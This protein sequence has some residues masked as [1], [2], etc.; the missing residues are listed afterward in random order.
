[1]RTSH[2]PND[3]R[4]YELCDRYGIYVIDEANLET[5]GV[6]GRLT[7]DPQWLSA[8]VERASRMVERDKNHPSVV[9]WS[10]GNESGMGPNHAAMAGW[11]REHDPTRPIHYE[12]AAARPRDPAWVDVVS[13]MYTRIP[14]LVKMAEDPAED[15]PVVLCEYAYA[16]GNAVGNLKEYWDA[17]RAHDRLLGGFIWDWVDKGLRRKDADGREYWAYGGDYGDEPNDGTMVCNGIVLPDRR[18]EPELHEVRKVYQR[19]ETT[20]EDAAAGRLRIRNDYAFRSLDFVEVLWSVEEDGHVVDQ[21]RLPATR[22]RAEAGG[23]AHPRA[24]PAQ[25]EAGDGV[26]PERAL[27]A[28]GRR[29]RGPSAATSSPGSSWPLPAAPAAKAPRPRLAAAGRPSRRRRRPSR[30]PAVGFCVDRRPGERAPSSRSV[31]ARASSSPPRSSRTS[32]GC[33]ST[34]TSASCSSTTC[35]SGLAVWKAGGAAAPCR[36]RGAGRAALTAGRARHRRG[37][38]AR[39]PAR[40]TSRPTPSTAAATSSSRPASPRAAARCPSC[41]A[42]ACRWRCRRHWRR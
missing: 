10:L 16:R 33:R 18:P 34:T 15:R 26:V 37:D 3:P 7:N 32:G 39:R 25:G 40:P 20:A 17:I 30:S 22:P 28:R 4:W 13:R 29:A 27:R 11:I 14:E 35:R 42:S 8:F 24:S 2:Y 41:R 31:S 19:V 5:H 23:R 9:M 12:G 36:Q 38:A 6:T 1:M 21:G